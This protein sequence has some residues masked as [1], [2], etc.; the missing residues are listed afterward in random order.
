MDE[1]AAPPPF[2][3][4]ANPPP[5]PPAFQPPPSGFAGAPPPPA[6]PP[7]PVITPPGGRRGK[8]GRGWMVLAIILFIFLVVSALLNMSHFAH[9][10]SYG[11]TRVTRA[12]G[13]RLE[14][15]LT[16]DNDASSKIAVIEINGIITSRNVDQ[17]F[18]MVEVIK[19]ELKRAQ[20]DSRVKA[21]I[22]K[23][24]SPGGEVL[25][26]DEI[27]N[28]LN[29]FQENSDKPVIAS[30]GNL[31]ASGGYYVSSPCR[32][33]VANELT[34]TGSIGV[35]MHTWN[36]RALMDKVGVTPET[37]KSGKF[38]D[39]LSGERS[40][41]EIPPEERAMVQKLI[42]E[43]Y[44]K[45]RGVVAAGRKKAADL[46]KGEGRPLSKDWTDYADGRVLSGSEAY[47]LGFVDQLGDFQAAVKRA[48]KIAGISRANLVEYQ[49]RYDLGDFLRVFGKSQA[50]A[51][52]VDLGFDPPKL[53]MGQLYFLS[54]TLVN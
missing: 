31:A 48:E 24:D 16:E 8:S 23:V 42:D 35:I 18:N 47:Q 7:P 52:K 36:Y 4:P 6:G 30:M 27:Y 9:S 26:S 37:F 50:P 17:G 15:V 25:A 54:P 28:L 34:I 46:N 43:T 38:K 13:P 19:A 3:P 14:E 49:Q 5:N 33:I 22:L 53:Q 29:Q 40:P 44:H 20:E 39:M 41:S 1:N 32:W 45:F 21:V 10:V 51:I 11:S 12:A 2:T